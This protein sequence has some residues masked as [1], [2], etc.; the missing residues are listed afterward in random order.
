M[1]KF[2]D[3]STSGIAL[4]TVVAGSN[5]TQALLSSPGSS[6]LQLSGTDSSTLCRVTGAIQIDVTAIRPPLECKIITT[7]ATSNTC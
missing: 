3:L 4:G 7:R 6:V 1:A 2:L 5:H